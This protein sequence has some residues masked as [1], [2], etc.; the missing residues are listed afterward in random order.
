MQPRPLGQVLNPMAVF[1]PLPLNASTKLPPIECAALLLDLDGTLLDI[2]PTPDQVVV[3]KNLPETLCKVRG[4]LGDALAIITGRPIDDVDALLPGVAYAVAGEHGGAIRYCP[5]G[6]VDRPLLAELPAGWREAAE[7]LV[8]SHPGALLEHKQRGFTLH[9]RAAREHG[10]SLQHSLEHLVSSQ[11]DRFALL[12]ARMAWEV[13][14]RGADK[15]TALAKL[16]EQAPFA[17]RRPVF[18][19][20]DVTDEDAIETARTRG[21]AGLRVP[22][23]FGDP[24]AVR[25]W[26]GALADH[27]MLTKRF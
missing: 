3:A 8:A 19:G 14:P 5:G 16:M 2:A 18:V 20:D 9:Y 12:P 27:D 13:R 23:M 10:A 22:E 4:L 1:P 25:A 15:G 6:P 11:A 24:A 26:L 21:G 17:K 7:R